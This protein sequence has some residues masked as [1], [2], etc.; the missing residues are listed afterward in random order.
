MSDPKPSENESSP[1]ATV[2][3]PVVPPAAKKKAASLD[4]QLK[5]EAREKAREAGVNPRWLVP[6]MLGLMIFGL[7][8]VVV[9]Y[10]SNM[11]W[12]IPFQKAFNL[13]GN[14]NLAVGFTFLIAG[15]GLTTRW[16]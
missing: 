16:R 4:K 8:Y 15:F 7:V 13:N 9:A 2:K 10:L 11:Q 5:R 12:P 1:A 3:K 6:T 14:W